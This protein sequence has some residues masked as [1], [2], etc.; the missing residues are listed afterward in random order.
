MKELFLNFIEKE[1]LQLDQ[2]P[3]LLA[4]SGG[5]DS[6]VML[7]LFRAAAFPFG[8]AHCN[9]SLRG[10]ASE[11]DAQLVKDTAVR[12]HIPYYSVK[13]DTDAIARQRGISIQMAARELRYEWLEK[14]RKEEG[15]ELI[16][17]AHHK[18]DTIETQFFNLIKG[19]G[20]KGLLG[21]PA[22]NGQ[23]IRPISFASRSQ[24]E[25]YQ[26]IHQLDFRKDASNDEVKYSR[27][28]IRHLVIPVFK[29]LNP[30]LEDTMAEN[31]QRF[32]E[33][34]YL[35]QFALDAIRQAAFRESKTGYWLDLNILRQHTQALP[36]I[37]YE[38]L[39]PFGV[40][41]KQAGQIARSVESGQTGSTFYTK[42]HLLLLNRDQ[43][44]IEA[45]QESSAI[46]EVT[47]QEDE[48]SRQV[49]GG[50][51]SLR[52]VKGQP[53][54]YPEHEFQA[55]MDAEV[56]KFPVRLRHWQAGDVFQPLGMSGQHQKLK[57]FFNNNKISRFEKERMWIVEDAQERICWI[58][59]Y[60][61]DDRFKI[62]PDTQ[63]YWVFDYTGQ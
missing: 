53:E 22:R 4:V 54:H 6:M 57:D 46:S 15:Y 39:T 43:L 47:V 12:H 23:V 20:I 32:K 1:G 31:A 25:D 19:C 51:I 48:P 2:T 49:P 45:Q 36:T 58:I 28:K 60:R 24:L 13:F 16:A 34:D 63:A 18:N 62:T 52:Y 27:N 35:F 21:I 42:K 29:E 44:L 10:E 40:N 38:L 56:L 3:T 33:T 37:L 14:I 41:S 5:L 9:F 55:F 50:R 8:I 59:G 30:A 61:L 17:T 7:D 26:R 11:K